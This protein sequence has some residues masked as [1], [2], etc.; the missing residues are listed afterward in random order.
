M[1]V[2]I[3]CKQLIRCMAK[4]QIYARLRPAPEK[5]RS[6]RVETTDQRVRVVTGDGDGER[7]FSSSPAASH[8]FKFRRVFGA[9]ATQ[10]RECMCMHVHH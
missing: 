7:P 2:C 9:A 3:C 8:C 6:R 10:V 5:L 4:I 1:Y